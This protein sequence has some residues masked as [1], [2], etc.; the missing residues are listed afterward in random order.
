MLIGALSSLDGFSGLA[1]AAIFW[2]FYNREVT[3]GG[4]AFH[5]TPPFLATLAAV[6]TIPLTLLYLGYREP[7]SAGFL[8][9]ILGAAGVAARLSLMD[10]AARSVPK[11]AEAAGFAL[12]MSV[13]NLAAWA[14]NTVG[15]KLYAVLSPGGP[16]MTMATLI[17]VSSATTTLALPLLRFIPS[18]KT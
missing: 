9:V 12:F 13:F 15:G 5:L 8:T 18:G 1:G 6:A 16:H 11:G 10:L 17:L 14:S 3:L 2:R 4:R 7:Y